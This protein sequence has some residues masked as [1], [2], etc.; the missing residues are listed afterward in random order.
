MTHPAD[1][2]A[3]DIPKKSKSLVG[4]TAKR[5][6]TT[7]AGSTHSLPGLK[8]RLHSKPVQADEQ[9]KSKRYVYGQRLDI[10]PSAHTRSSLSSSNHHGRS[11]FVSIQTPERRPRIPHDFVSNMMLLRQRLP[12]CLLL[13]PAILS[14]DCP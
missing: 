1:T 12:H 9:S 3:Q 2:S 11:A 10:E 6:T 7:T 5:P 4:K 13:L 8:R 14:I